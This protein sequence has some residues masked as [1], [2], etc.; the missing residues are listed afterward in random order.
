MKVKVAVFVIVEE[1][2]VKVN[3]GTVVKVMVETIVAV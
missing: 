3:R 1:V 2:K